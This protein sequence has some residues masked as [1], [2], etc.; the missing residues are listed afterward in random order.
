MKKK[1][2]NILL[3]LAVAVAPMALAACGNKTYEEIKEIDGQKFL[4]TW[5]RFPGDWEKK[6]YRCEAFQGVTP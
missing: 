6:D 2:R 1:S 5:T 4:C 3:A